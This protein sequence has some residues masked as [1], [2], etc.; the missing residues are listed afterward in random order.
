MNRLWFPGL[1]FT[2]CGRIGPED[3]VAIRT[4]GGALLDTTLTLESVFGCPSRGSSNLPIE[5]NS[6]R[7]SGC[8][9]DDCKPKR[10]ASHCKGV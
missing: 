7:L 9:H 10:L 4:T 8:L 2:L 5:R 6:W 1:V 3:T